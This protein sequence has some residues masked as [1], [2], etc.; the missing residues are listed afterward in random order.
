MNLKFRQAPNE[1]AKNYAKE[2]DFVNM[3][4]IV[5]CTPPNEHINDFGAKFF[6]DTQ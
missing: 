1:I 6:P 3:K 5:E 4:G 2:E